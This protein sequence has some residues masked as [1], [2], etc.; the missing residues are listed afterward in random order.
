MKTTDR[1]NQPMNPATLPKA[2]HVEQDGDLFFVTLPENRYATTY[3]P[4]IAVIHTGMEVGFDYESGKAA[5]DAVRAFL[6]SLGITP[7]F[8]Y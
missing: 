1:D 5:Q 8:D 2:V 6:V 7:T 4:C 3:I